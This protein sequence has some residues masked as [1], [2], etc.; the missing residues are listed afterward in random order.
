MIYD[1]PISP[2]ELSA[3]IGLGLRREG[4]L[5]SLLAAGQPRGWV[6]GPRC[7]VTAGLPLMGNAV[8]ASAQERLI[9]TRLAP[10]APGPTARPM[11]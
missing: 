1:V 7:H 10:L 3:R 9:I 11:G 8:V 2:E 6:A 5:D 4:F